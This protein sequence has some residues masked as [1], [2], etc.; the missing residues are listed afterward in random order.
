[1]S[2]EHQLRR[3]LMT[4]LATFLPRGDARKSDGG[5]QHVPGRELD[6]AQLALESLGLGA[7]AGA[8]RPETG[9]ASSAL[10]Y[11]RSL[12]FLIRSPSY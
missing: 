1:M 2:S 12:A 11:P 8:R 7:F 3:R 10:A 9:S 6:D 5:A 4:A